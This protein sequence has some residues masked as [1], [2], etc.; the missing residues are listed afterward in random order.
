MRGTAGNCR[1]MRALAMLMAV[2]LLAA[3]PVLL[4][5]AAPAAGRAG[6]AL[7]ERDWGTCASAVAEPAMTWYLA[8][9]CTEAGYETW[10]LVQNPGDKAADIAMDFQ[11]FS[12][13]VTGPRDTV[14][15][16]NRKTYNVADYVVSFE[17][18]TKVRASSGVVCERA[19]YGGNRE[20]GAGATG[21]TTPSDTWYL[22]EGCTVPG[23]ETWVLVQNP[24]T[25][26]VDIE[27]SLQTD[28]GEV[29]GPQDTI[30]AGRRRT[31]NLGSY[32]TSYNVSTRLT[33]SGG[34]VCER[35]MYS[36]DIVFHEGPD[37]HEWGTDSNGITAAS[38]TCYLAEGCTLPG[39]ETWVLVQNPGPGAADVRMRLLT[40]SGEVAGP[41]DTIPAGR[42]RTYDLSKYAP[43]A[44]VATVVDASAPVVVERAMYGGERLWGTCAQ[45]CTALSDTWYLAEGCTAKS[46]ET[47]LSLM[48]PGDAPVNVTVKLQTEKGEV[49]GP[50]GVIGPRR[51]KTFNLG[52]YVTSYNVASRVEASGPVA[53]ERP[54]YGQGTNRRLCA[55]VE[56]P[57]LYPFTRDES[58][59][60]GRWP[61]GSTDYPFFGAPREG[62]RL[63]AGIDIYPAA[64]AGAP[65]R[66]LK[67][68]TVV[69]TGLFYTRYTGEQTFAVL[70]DHGD[71]VANYG[72]LSPLDGW[73]QPGA[74]VSRG[75]VIGLVS[76]TLQLH[77]EMYARGTTSW[78]QWYGP[79]PANL[80]DPTDTILLLY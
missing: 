34:V 19:M 1:T 56:G 71:F 20:W 25:A 23:F 6:R 63:H 4:P 12:G 54:M 67:A 21:V 45:G 46:F 44:S 76:G 40:D 13:V 50:A 78:L 9:G 68:G 62:T 58:I 33:A 2:A 69:K 52:D 42:R 61:P 8:E 11:T 32:V 18:S 15:P 79:Q 77:F 75:Q 73:V 59:A 74:T 27:M 5:Q 35:A 28:Q 66:A 14:P 72:E 30:P 24:G 65:V 53:C 80:I 36:T 29:A 41:S 17:V 26:P 57:L 3:T 39:F 16:G 51:R 7:E 22:S 31:Y 43:G 70:V 37:E 49:D 47:W 60:C 10:I 48:N 55:P 64:G 38:T